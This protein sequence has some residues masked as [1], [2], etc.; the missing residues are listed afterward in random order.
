MYVNAEGAY[1]PG[2]VDV[3]GI[4]KTYAEIFAAFEDGKT[5]TMLLGSL[6]LPLTQLNELEATF[7]K[8]DGTYF[9]YVTVY[10]ND[11]ISSGALDTRPG[12]IE[13]VPLSNYPDLAQE[14]LSL[15]GT[16]MGQAIAAGGTETITDAY[17]SNSGNFL[18]T[19]L[20]KIARDNP[21]MPV[22][23]ISMGDATVVASVVSETIISGRGLSEAT[24][25]AQTR[26]EVNSAEYMVEIRLHIT[27]VSIRIQG[28]ATA[29]TQ[30]AA[31]TT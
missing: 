10:N 7:E 29:W 1:S 3:S 20:A 21:T 28:R 15:F 22:L 25:E 13:V 31:P 14:V 17:T 11:S 19:L 5:V 6:L 8:Y 23:G 30:P 18:L 2:A 16:W 26:Y 4:D 9:N 12:G 27:N 24:F